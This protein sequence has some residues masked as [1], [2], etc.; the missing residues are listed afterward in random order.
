MPQ[1]DLVVRS[2]RTVTP[3]GVVPAAL[4]ISGGRISAI[5]GY[6]APLS[7]PEET[8]LGTVA[9]LPGCVDMNIAVQEPGQPLREGYARTAGAAVRGGVTTIAVA[10]APARPAITDTAGLRAH[11][12]A[13]ADSGGRLNVVFL[14]GITRRTSPTDLAG[15]HTA[16]AVAFQCSLSDGGA[17]DIAAVQ[18]AGL[19]KAMV[20]LAAIGAPLLVHTED[21]GEL[22]AKEDRG[23][24]GCAP[25]ERPSRAE[26]RGLERV[27]AAA[28]AAGARAHVCPFSA[29]ECTALLAAARSLGIT[30]SAHTCP[31]Y[32]CLSAEQMPSDFG[33]RPPLRS[34]ANRTA[35]W[36]ALLSDD[37][38]ITTIGSG[39]RP[40]T[41]IAALP[42][43]LPALW[44]AAARRGRGL[45]DLADWTSGRPAGLLGLGAKGTIAIGGDA[46]LAAFCPDSEQQVPSDDRGPYAG[47]RLTGRVLGTW[48]SGRA[49]FPVPDSARVGP[50]APAGRRRPAVT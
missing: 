20:E 47:R 18:E 10:P 4:G 22:A 5:G 1:F 8:D 37:P 45:A 43:T 36:N 12:E 19:R 24:I 30:V 31:H 21:A 2:Q 46:D 14:G 26:R 41:G 29:A 17:P 3:E 33:A 40:G 6:D 35:L 42:W 28:R 32:L 15:L 48:V 25:A 44:T 9:L 50:G 39:H 11:T 34:A 13:A 27:I 23:G 7:S 49:V 38:V 16:G